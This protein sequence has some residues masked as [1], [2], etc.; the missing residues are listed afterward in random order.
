[1]KGGHAFADRRAVSVHALE[2]PHLSARD[3]RAAAEV[4]LERLYPDALDGKRVV[5]VKNGRRTGSCLCL[6]CPPDACD[7]RTASSTRY[8]VNRLP[9]YTGEARFIGREFEERVQLEAGALV[10]SQVRTRN[11]GG[12]ACAA[13]MQCGG[14][15]W[16][17]GVGTVDA[18]GAERDGACRTFR[19]EDVRDIRRGDFFPCTG[20][21][22]LLKRS[23][24]LVLAAAVAVV[25]SVAVF[26]RHAERRKEAEADRRAMEERSRQKDEEAEAER[27]HMEMLEASYGALEAKRNAGAY[28]IASLVYRCLEADAKIENFAIAGNT[29]QLDLH[30]KDG[31]AVLSNFERERHIEEVRLSRS[32]KEGASEYV[33]YSG[34][35]RRFARAVPT[36][37][38]RSQQASW[39]EEQLSAERAERERK[40]ASSASSY[41]GQVRSLLMKSGCTEEYMQFRENGGH[42]ELEC[43]FKSGRE[44]LFRFLKEAEGMEIVSVRM[45][46]GIGAVETVVRMNTGISAGGK[47]LGKA[48]AVEEPE[49]FS[50]TPEE[51]GG[52]F[53]ERSVRKPAAS[54]P[55]RV[56]QEAHEAPSSRRRAAHLVYV[57]TGGSREGGSYV[58]FKDSR[59]GRL[60]RLE[61]MERAE[62]AGDFCREDGGV[63]EVH[64]GG[65]VYEVV[66]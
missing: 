40:G 15:A 53:H 25:L 57:G 65:T 33:T 43:A 45:R 49:S 61:L 63:Y 19:E 6:V 29:F 37:L 30:T 31:L 20:S 17:Q 39:Y 51:L 46:S 10:W 64:L 24:R 13:E 14:R 4:Q 9:G 38:S 7:G 35:V 59:E 54:P 18:S 44:A 55:K 58:F 22:V 36:A 8:V 60:H 62:G 41:A 50:V 23:L 32:A 56:E 27:K 42:A 52:A 47:E 21:L 11:A 12:M 26:S 1:M 5:I 28:Q 3:R 34:R 48:C 66:K 2:L 16:P